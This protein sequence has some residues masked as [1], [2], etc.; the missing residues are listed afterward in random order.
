MIWFSLVGYFFSE[1]TY[2]FRLDTNVESFTYQWR[3]TVSH[4]FM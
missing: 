2:I 3:T 1:V 4:C